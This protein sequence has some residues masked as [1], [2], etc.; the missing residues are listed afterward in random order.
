MNWRSVF[1]KNYQAKIALFM[2]AVFLWFFVV[3][4][5]NYNQVL[6]VPIVM[7]GLKEGKV[8]LKPPVDHARVRFYGKG[9]SLLLL[10]VVGDA[11]FVL[12]LSSINYF[13]DFPLHLDLLH[14]ASGINVEVMDIVFPDTVFIRIDDSIEKTLSVK[15]MLAVSLAQNYTAVGSLQ[16]SPDTVRALGAKTILEGMRTIPTQVK[17]Y[18]NA[19]GSI[20]VRLDLIPPEEGEIQLDPAEVRVQLKV[21]K[22]ESK[23]LNNVAVNVIECAPERIGFAVPGAVNIRLKGAKSLLENLQKDQ[24]MVSVSAAQNPKDGGYYKPVLHLPDG[25]ELIAIIPDSV[26]IEYL[27]PQT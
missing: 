15:P 8:F 11:R 18:E 4:S 13:F 6:D 14:W 21:E 5:Q 22:V 26:K 12:D 16:V 20:N 9:T 7:T 19:T 1:F 27:E 2:M 23:L 10:S 25:I 17:S 24:V 3:T